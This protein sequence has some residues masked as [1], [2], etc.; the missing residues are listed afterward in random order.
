MVE[1]SKFKTNLKVFIYCTMLTRFHSFLQE[2]ISQGE[3]AN[4][5]TTDDW[6]SQSDSSHG[7]QSAPMQMYHRDQSIDR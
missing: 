4:T 7:E 2:D 5:A 1:V 3:S 6:E